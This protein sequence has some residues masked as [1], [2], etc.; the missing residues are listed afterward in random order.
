[1]SSAADLPYRH[2]IR[3]AS[4]PL[5][6]L[7]VVLWGLGVLAIRFGAPLGL[8]AP[9][10][11]A[12]LFLATVPLAWSTVNFAAR[13]TGRRLASLTAA[14]QASMPALLLDGLAI[15]WAPGLYGV[16]AQPVLAHIGAWLLWF[17]GICLAVALLWDARLATRAA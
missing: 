10:P 6:G 15:A 3:V 9:T 17:V 14:A 7:S 4:A 2:M 13:L 8:F 1:M 16:D 11:L 12:I 5:L